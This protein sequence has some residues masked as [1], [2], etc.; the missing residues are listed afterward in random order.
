M[1]KSGGTDSR[2]ARGAGFTKQMP[3]ET[4]WISIVKLLCVEKKHRFLLLQKDLF[5]NSYSILVNYE[6]ILNYSFSFDRHLLKGN[7]MSELEIFLATS[8]RK[9][10]FESKQCILFL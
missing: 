5:R 9:C 3:V 2:A 8:R 1:L 6:G 10:P 7:F 4:P